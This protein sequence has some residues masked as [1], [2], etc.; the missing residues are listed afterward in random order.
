MPSTI[1]KDISKE[2]YISWY[3]CKYEDGVPYWEECILDCGYDTGHMELLSKDEAIGEPAVREDYYEVAT[4]LSAASEVEKFARGIKENVL[5]GDWASLSDKL[6]YPITIDGHTLND[7]SDFLELDIAGNL[8]QEF[9]NAISEESCRKMFCNW[10]GI[11]MG[12][13]GQIWFTDVDEGSGTWEL[14]IIGINGML[15][16]SEGNVTPI[17]GVTM[18]DSSKIASIIITNG[19]TGEKK[20]ITG[21]EVYS[22]E[23]YL[24]NDLRKLYGQLDFSVQAVENERVGYQY[25]MVLYDAGGSKLQKITPYKDGLTVD[26]VFYQYDDTGEGAKASLRLMEYMEYIFNPEA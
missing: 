26:G 16:I 9:V 3:V 1:S 17:A 11:M 23:Y 2:T 5:S 10:Q 21:E 24:Y 7:S 15:D 13:T 19:N 14:K 4:S 12:A 25:S 8:S 6:V 20:T 18:V 22:E